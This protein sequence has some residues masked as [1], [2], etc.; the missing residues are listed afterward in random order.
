MAVPKKYHLH[1]RTT[2]QACTMDRAKRNPSSIVPAKEMG[3][4]KSSTHPTG[5]GDFSS[6]FIIRR[7]IAACLPCGL[8][9]SFP[10][11]PARVKSL[12][13]MKRPRGDELKRQGGNS[14]DQPLH[15]VKSQV[16]SKI[17]PH[18]PASFSLEGAAGQSWADAKMERPRPSPA[19]PPDKSLCAVFS[20]RETS[21]YT[22]S[23]WTR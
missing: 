2:I 15:Q 9:C 18:D 19:G 17:L 13:G 10:G 11:N 1:R 7:R 16:G 4:A 20:A 12:S 21:R 23:R 6:P 22:R 5:A 14:G 8:S 3:L